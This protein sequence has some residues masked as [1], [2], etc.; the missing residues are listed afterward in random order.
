MPPDSNTG[1]RL[2]TSQD[3]QRRQSFLSLTPLPSD[4]GNGHAYVELVFGG[5]SL[6]E[7]R[8]W[9]CDSEDGGSA[10]RRF[11]E[12]ATKEMTSSETPPPGEEL[13]LPFMSAPPRKRHL[14]SSLLLPRCLERVTYTVGSMRILRL[15]NE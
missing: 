4:M 6:R 13:S 3:G 11:E 12:V 8:G 9:R 5:K 7:L 1:S 2:E 10:A 15:L 14:F